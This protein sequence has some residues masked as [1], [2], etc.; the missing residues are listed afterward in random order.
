MMDKIVT[1]VYYEGVVLIFTERGVV[2]EAIRIS[3]RTTG[4]IEIRL[5]T[6]INLD[7]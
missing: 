1:A 3:P 4:E 6:Q 5:L 2:Y 7:K